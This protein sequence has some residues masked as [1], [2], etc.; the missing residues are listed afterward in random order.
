MLVHI[1]DHFSSK[2]KFNLS[3]VP[4]VKTDRTSRLRA[5]LGIILGFFMLCLSLFELYSFIKISDTDNRSFIMVEI[6]A[7]IMTFVAL[8]IIANSIKSSIRYKK[9]IFNGK[10]FSIIYRPSSDVKHTFNVALSEYM[11][12]RLRVL[13]TQF[14]IFNINRYIIDLYHNDTSKIIPL[15]I[16][17]N[18]KN[19]RKI[20]EEYSRFFKLPALILS[21]RGLVKREFNDL[22]KSIIELSKEGKLPF[23]ASG[24]YPNPNSIDI[25]EQNDAVIIKPLFNFIYE[26]GCFARF[27]TFSCFFT[28]IL[29]FFLITYIKPM[30]LLTYI[31]LAFVGL[32]IVSLLAIL[33]QKPSN[34][35][36]ITDNKL[37]IEQNIFFLFK[38]N[39]SIDTK[40]VKGI[41]LSYNPKTDKYNIIFTDDKKLI[42][43]KGKIPV[44]DLLWIKDF[45]IRKLVG[46]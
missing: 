8:G 20:W 36:V 42:S 29:S 24:K 27:Y 6:F 19:I 22:N 46:N 9:F 41:E 43:Y 38:R 34:N 28:L 3:K 31:F 5:L 15:Y 23:I 1:P 7:L 25:E 44:N 37:I 14:G 10:D 11:G 4:C 30:I 26:L 16:S 35:I 40:Q 13:F 39:I 33:I 21:E 45:I 17:T 32:F 18:D 12:V 2:F